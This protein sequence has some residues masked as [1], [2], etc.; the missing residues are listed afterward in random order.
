MEQTLFRRLA[1]F[2]G[3]CTLDAADA[4]C[5]GP[6]EEA[7]DGG[8]PPSSTVLAFSMLGGLA[9]LV[10]KNLVVQHTD[11]NGGPRFSLL[12]TMHEFS[13]EQLAGSGEEEALRRR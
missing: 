9:S 2:A 11:P 7:T 3:G 12:E 4:V 1:V 8:P 6:A 10:E 13:R 5:G